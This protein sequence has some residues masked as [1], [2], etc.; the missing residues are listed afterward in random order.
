MDAVFLATLIGAA[1]FGIGDVL[2]QHGGLLKNMDVS[3]RDRANVNHWIDS[4]L[5]K[6][7]GNEPDDPNK[8]INLTDCTP[9]ILA[10]KKRSSGDQNAKNKIFGKYLY[11]NYS[12]KE[13]IRMADFN[14]DDYLSDEDSVVADNSRYDWE[15]EEELIKEDLSEED[16]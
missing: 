11:I 1:S 9:E 8:I 3:E 12:T 15:Q 6:L 7:F 5:D 2:G 4:K 16:Q 10:Q 14:Y 13:V